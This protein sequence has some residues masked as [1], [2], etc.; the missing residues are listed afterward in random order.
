M[1]W[2]EQG[3]SP[4]EIVAAYPQLTLADV[5]A[6]LAFYF[7]NR[8]TMDRQIRKDRDFTDAMRAKQHMPAPTPEV[9]TDADAPRVSP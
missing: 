4:D 9:S 2:S 5:H 7:D 1:L 6:A 8:E 3:E